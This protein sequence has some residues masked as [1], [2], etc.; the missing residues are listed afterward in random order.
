MVIDFNDEQSRKAACSIVVTEGGTVIE[1][2]DEHPSNISHGMDMIV[3]GRLIVSRF[4]QPM[5]IPDPREVIE[6][7]R[8]IVLKDSQYW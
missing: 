5:N 2:I 8:S 1:V 7:G 6:V 4:S 3:F